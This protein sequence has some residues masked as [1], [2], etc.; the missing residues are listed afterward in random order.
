LVA[1]VALAAVAWALR[2]PVLTAAARFLTVRDPLRKADAIFV[3]GG[4]PDI[5]PFAAA[6]LYRQGWAPRVLIP[7][8]ETGPAA[9]LGI[10]PTQTDVFSQVLQAKGVPSSA[11]RI[12]T[13]PGG[14]SSTT[15]D[16]QVLRGYVLRHH[17]RSVIAV[18][19]AYHS[20]RARWA[21]RH[22]LKG[23]GVRVM[24]YSAPSIGYDETNWWRSEDGMMAYFEEYV[25]FA[26]Y[27]LTG[28]S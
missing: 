5:R 24:M 18:T 22:G 13:K 26:R 15:Q 9:V 27:L 28:G 21:L 25:K 6:E 4:D 19:T 3:F 20:R 8:M 12:L 11:I 2:A 17:L 16:V 1:T 7:G 10:V 14:T 23:T